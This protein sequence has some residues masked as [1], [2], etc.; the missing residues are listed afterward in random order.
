MRCTAEILD[1]PHS[2]LTSDSGGWYVKGPIDKKASIISLVF[3]ILTGNIGIAI[4]SI[5][6]LNTEHDS[7]PL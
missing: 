4:R 5:R 3:G 7:T 2:N 6:E 1:T